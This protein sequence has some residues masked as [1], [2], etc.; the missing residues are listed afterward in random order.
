MDADIILTGGTVVTMNPAGDVWEDGAVAVAGQEIVAVGPAAEIAA[1]ADSAEVMDCRGCV[2]MPGLI[3]A[4][5]HMPMSLLRGLADDRQLD[6]WLYGYMLPVERTFVSEDFCRLGTLLSCAEMLRSGTTCFVDMYYFEEAVAHTAAEVGMRGICG[7]TIMKWST[8]DAESYDES[9]AYCEKFIQRWKDHPLITPA[10]APHAPYSC[11]EAILQKTRNIALRYDVP[12]LIH[13]SETEQEVVETQ[14]AEA[15]PP[16]AWAASLGLFEAKTVAAHCVYPRQGELEILRDYGVGVA[17]NPT[18]NLKLASGMAPIAEM[19]AK[20]IHVAV[21]TDGAASNNDQDMFEEVRLAALLP[22]GVER[23]P[24]AVP[25]RRA[26]AMATIEGARAVHLDHLIGSLEAGKRADVVIV[27]MSPTHLTPT[28]QP[29]HETVYSQLVYSAKSSDVLH[30][31]VNGRFLLRDRQLLTID[32]QA[33]HGEA[34]EYARRINVF[35][36]EREEDLLSKLVAISSVEH[37]ETFEVQVK[38]RVPESF[39]LSAMLE[40]PDVVIGRGSERE[41]YDTYL[42]FGSDQARIRYREDFVAASDGN[43]QPLYFLTLMEPA[44]RVSYEHA[45]ILSRARYV[46]Q[47]DRSLRFY[48]EYFQPVELRE[49]QKHRQRLHIAFRGTGFVINKDTMSRP[50][51]GSVYLEIKSRTWSRKDAV[52][53]SELIGQLLTILGIEDR[54]LL[55]TDYVDFE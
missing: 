2:V 9:L 46:A 17:H 18:S 32:L 39:N 47:A 37:Q 21:G 11:T 40:H 25:A 5:T 35:L 34:Q 54:S 28:Y 16:I 6:V 44:E 26:L 31:I 50:A 23:D 7:E 33:V 55:E 36:A 10:V 29:V 13:L 30:V 43:V 41:Q 48:R 4:H 14:A 51:E 24:L 53:K 12:L 15:L 42:L 19:I 49:V 27:D 52:R 22:K 8:P 38:A 1:E 45:V 20:G 3:N